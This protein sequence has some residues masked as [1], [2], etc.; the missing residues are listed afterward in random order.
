MERFIQ[1]QLEK[2]TI[3]TNIQFEGSDSAGEYY[4]AEHPINAEQIELKVTKVDFDEL[5]LDFFE[6]LKYRGI[7]RYTVEQKKEGSEDWNW[8]FDFDTN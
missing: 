4:T 5:G 3:L 7:E 1:N 8:L 2:R 6:K